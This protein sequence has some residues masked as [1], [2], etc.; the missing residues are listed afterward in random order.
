MLDGEMAEMTM[1]LRRPASFARFCGLVMLVS[2]EMVASCAAAPPDWVAPMREVHAR[3]RGVSGSCAHFGDSLTETLAYWAPLKLNRKRASPEFEHAYEVASA[4]L[5]LECWR[6]WK[7]PRFGNRSG[8]GIDW[9]AENI[10]DWLKRLNPEIAVILF[11]TN[12]L[13]GRS[14]ADYEQRLESV[15]Q[16]CLANGTVP[17]LTTIPPRHGFE[18]RA[19]EMADGQRR[20]AT[21]LRIPLIDLHGEILRRRPDD[22][23]GSRLPPLPGQTRQDGHD[24]LTLIAADGVHLSHPAGFRDDYSEESLQNNGYALRNALT[25]LAYAD[26]VRRVCERQELPPQAE[27]LKSPSAQSI[28][29]VKAVVD[30]QTA[31]RAPAPGSSVRSTALRF[32]THFSKPDA[33]F[34]SAP[35]LTEV[36]LPRLTGPHAIWGATGR[37]DAGNLYVGISALGDS[38]SAVLVQLP[39]SGGDAAILGSVIEQLN[40]SGSVHDRESQA[41]IHS[42]ICQANDGAIYFTSMDEDGEKDDGSQLPIWGSHLWRIRPGHPRWEHV[43]K[44]SDALIALGTTGRYVYALGYFNHMLYQFDTAKGTHRSMAVGSHR[45]HT[46]RNLLVDLREHVYVP[47]VENIENPAPGD[48][49]VTFVKEQPVKSSLVEFDTDLKEVA[50]WPLPDYNPT[51]DS[52]SHG[53]VGFAT[54]QSG[55]IV[56]TTHSGALWCLTPAP[57][58]PALLERLGWFHPDGSSYPS[59]IYCPTGSRFVCG[60]TRSADGHAW[61]VHDLE[62]WTSRTVPLDSESDK[63]LRGAT[64]G[65]YGTNTLDEQGRGYLVGA[66]DKCLLLRF[67]WPS[68]P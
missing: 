59:A 44:T 18:K 56:F 12:D 57:H 26:V 24:V 58:G 35:Q 27:P 36:P 17:I 13:P 4:R 29:S 60:L 37:D 51:H 62:N 22:W 10:D 32:G 54:L 68:A 65:V 15:L 64:Y 14:N 8:A 48:R 33:R 6:D 19:G 43:L 67:E 1:D 55:R 5:A 20:L 34:R 47:R 21:K 63:L 3:Y 46:S 61:V 38:R 9:A 7:G 45:G 31:P 66:G 28:P 2:L 50:R 30:R 41:K 16:K 40:L 53:I 52:S 11:G 39:A 23:D 49:A 25:L 42:K